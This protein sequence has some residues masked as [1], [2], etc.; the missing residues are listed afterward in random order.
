MVYIMKSFRQFEI[1]SR[2]LSFG[3]LP[4]WSVLLIDVLLSMVA[5]AVSMWIGGG[6]FNY[7]FS[8]MWPVWA[9]L[10]LVVGLQSLMFLAFRTYSGVLRYST[11]VDTIRVL[12]SVVMTGAVL[13]ILNAVSYKITGVH[14]CLT[15]ATIMYVFVAFVFMFCLRV[16]IKTIYETVQQNASGSRKILIYGT[17]QAGVAIAKMLRSSG[18]GLYRP[19][20]LTARERTTTCSA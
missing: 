13:L 17:K 5:F 8:N 16:G 3:Y 11:F 15:T 6:L 12:L 1:F 14:L 19:V 2:F 10:L 20:G 7:G 4:R 9:Q 18:E